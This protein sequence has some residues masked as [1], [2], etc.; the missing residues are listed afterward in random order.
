[1][2]TNY[3][4][5]KELVEV[6]LPP[7]DLAAKLTMAGI[8]VDA[9]DF[10]GDDAVLEIDLTSNRPDCLSH[11][12]IAR[13]AAAVLGKTAR[14][15]EAK[16]IESKT[17]TGDVTSVEILAPA[18]CPR[19]TARVIRGVKIGPSPDWMV[20]RLESLGQRGLNNVADITNYVMLEMG[21]PLHAFDLHQLRGERIVVRTA[22]SGEKITTL[23]GEERDLTPEMLVIADAERPVAIA[24][25]KGGEDS[26]IT[27][28]TVDVLLEAAG[29][30]YRGLVP[31][32]ARDRSRNR[33]EGFGPGGGPDRRDRWRRGF[34]RAPRRVSDK[35]GARLDRVP[36]LAL[37]G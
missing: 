3:N 27:D 37:L 4:W 6:D 19:Y 18:L 11:L 12:G 14:T 8:A 30:E 34:E 7:R 28:K 23:D 2:K 25:I 13:E 32:R 15:P 20:K 1:M 16:V 9:V 36:P 29:A 35:G 31:L 26:G 17:K 5:L 33:R 24:G 22:R 10:Y 21:Q